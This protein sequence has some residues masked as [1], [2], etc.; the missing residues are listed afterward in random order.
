MD[1]SFQTLKLRL[2]TLRV[3]VREESASFPMEAMFRSGDTWQKEPKRSSCF[4]LK[5]ISTNESLPHVRVN[6]KKLG[7]LA[8]F[9][10][11]FVTWPLRYKFCW[12]TNPALDQH[13]ALILRWRH[14]KVFDSFFNPW[15]ISG[16]YFFQKGSSSMF[17]KDPEEIFPRVWKQTKNLGRVCN[18]GSDERW[19]LP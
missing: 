12:I 9:T 3:A 7:L 13:R 16:I 11:N 8:A 18:R 4:R 17:T 15:T 14:R 2:K 5:S 1:W 10:L 6:F 19:P